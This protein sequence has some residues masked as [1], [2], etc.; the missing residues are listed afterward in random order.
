M[1]LKQ[2]LVRLEIRKDGYI[3][4]VAAPAEHH[5]DEGQ[6]VDAV[7]CWTHCTSRVLQDD[8]LDGLFGQEGALLVRKEMGAVGA[9]TFGEDEEGGVLSS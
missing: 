2:I 5:N 3:T 1:F 6:D 8:G 7:K 9:S 4:S